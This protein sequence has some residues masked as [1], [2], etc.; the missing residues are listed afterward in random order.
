MSFPSHSLQVT[1][2]RICLMISQDEVLSNTFSQGKSHDLVTRFSH[3]SVIL[4][5]IPDRFV[6][7]CADTRFV[8]LLNVPKEREI[9][10]Y[11][12]SAKRLWKFRMF[13]ENDVISFVLSFDRAFCYHVFRIDTFGNC[14]LC[15]SHFD[16]TTVES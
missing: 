10:L 16:L 5:Y 9:R 12:D 11:Y 3:Y 2:V 8:N 15:H 7:Q 14:T 1:T 13:D 4:E 6:T